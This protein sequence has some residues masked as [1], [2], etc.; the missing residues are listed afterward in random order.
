MTSC[1]T[2]WQLFVVGP[3]IALGLLALGYFGFIIYGFWTGKFGR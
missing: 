3:L 1:V 2:F